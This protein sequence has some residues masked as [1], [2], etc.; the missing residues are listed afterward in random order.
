VSVLVG[1]AGWSVA[2]RYLQS[3]PA[4]GTHLE[5][6]GRTF[7]IAEITTSFYR[8]HQAK[9]YAR[10]ALSVGDDFRFCVKTPRALTHEGRLICGRSADLDRFLLEVRGLGAK[11]R[12]LLVQLPPSLEF[13]PPDAA[14]FFRRLRR[15]VPAAVALV[16]EPRHKSWNT[17]AVDLQLQEL[18][19]S[20]AAVDPPRWDGDARPGGDHRLEYFR[21]H[22]S[23]RIYYSDYDSARL[24]ELASALNEAAL[25][26]RQVWCI[27]DNTAHGHAIGNALATQKRLTEIPN[28]LIS[29][30]ALPNWP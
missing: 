12:A 16:C 19:V 11:L 18:G 26:S 5:R 7:P 10:W 2:A 9:T 1:T 22:G 6:Y 15:R 4:I 25:R 3:I 27:F 23:P 30:P 13:D 28:A 14:R 24:G 8:H 17:D 20:R 21:M 29:A